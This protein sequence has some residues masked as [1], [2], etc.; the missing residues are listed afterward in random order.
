MK[1]L[2]MLVCVWWLFSVV[3]CL[4]GGPAR[5]DSDVQRRLDKL[6]DNV[7]RREVARLEVLWIPADTLTRTRLT[8]EM[9]ERQYYY[10][11]TVRE[12]RGGPLE[13]G[14]INV[15]GSLTVEPV[16][17]AP[18]LRRGVLFFDANGS[19]LGAI[20]VDRAGS[21]GVVDTV[22]VSLNGG[23]SSWIANTFEVCPRGG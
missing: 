8:Q 5:N 3:G 15:L 6:V 11:V 16:Y 21:R 12:I 10:K 14:L 17:E 18:D 20:Y 2:K 7:K 4:G 1:T 23:F 19:R 22:A 13:Q 9:L